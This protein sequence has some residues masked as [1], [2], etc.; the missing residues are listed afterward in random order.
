MSTTEELLKDIADRM[1][2]IETGA[3][4]ARD[5]MSED[6][7]RK[8]VADYFA[9]L[10][11]DDPI[12]RKMRH[13]GADD[14]DVL[15]GSKYGRMGLGVSD[16]EFLHDLQ[17]AQ[18]EAGRGAGPSEELTRVFKS[19]SSA[20]RAMDTAET[21]FGQ[22]LMGA[23]YV[24]DLWE[25]AR[26][27]SRVFSLI[28]SFEMNDSTAYLPVEVDIPEM[29]L[30]AESV[31]N[32][33]SNYATSKTGS[34]R[35]QVNAK[36]LGI[37]QMWSGELDEDSIIPFAPFLRGQAA[38]SLAHYSDSLVLNGD[39][40]TAAT[41]NIN[42]DDAAPAATKHFLA[43]DGIRHVGLVDNTA[44]S[45]ST[46]VG[47]EFGVADLMAQKG[48][49]V[50][51][52]YLHDWGHPTNPADLVFVGDPTTADKIAMFK[53]VLDSRKYNG[54]TD[55]L[56]GEV[57][58]ILGHPVI[59]SIAVPLTEADGKPSSV[60]PANNVKGS[61]VAFNRNGFVSGWRRQVKLATEYIPA[62]DQ[63]RI[64]YTLRLGFGRFTPT[65]AAAGIQSADVLYNI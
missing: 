61:V 7:L 60:T 15:K 45:A 40:T 64:V 44:N 26:P 62:T 43:F 9:D 52:T 18:R 21:G 46:L 38:K 28:R 58:R 5:A 59:S 11:D 22:Q 20:T 42:N 56:S 39:T 23:Q 14:T 33:S 8:F 51:Y 2:A 63:Y 25:A 65:G 32:N 49:L 36:K 13:G 31:N 34:N 10:S 16:I 53:D 27:D 55:L 47:T 48:R 50:D 3:N 12:V 37:H 57:G 4:E 35:V 41:G 6:N 17:T 30:M 1:S 19:V 54:G 24:G 29:I